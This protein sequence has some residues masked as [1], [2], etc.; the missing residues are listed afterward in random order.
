MEDMNARSTRILVPSALALA[1]V[2]SAP[3]ASAHDALTGTSPGAN[4]TID[5]APQSLLLTF[6][7]DVLK[8][9]GQI[10]V[11]GPDGKTVTKAPTTT[12]N[13]V[14]VPFEPSGNG[15]YAVTWRI[16]S[17]DGHP[18]SGQYSF[19]LKASANST[20]STG[21]TTPSATQSAAPSASS[22]VKGPSTPT[23]DEPGDNK[24][25][26]LVGGGILAALALAGGFLIARKRVKDDPR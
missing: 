18:V 6:N 21:T 17:S 24:P 23:T 9:G 1:A 19:T 14:S 13:R 10:A 22:T 8:V 7:E 3:A 12:G 25:K 26:L 20:T 16:T 15:T 11:K 2:V 5:K 4:T